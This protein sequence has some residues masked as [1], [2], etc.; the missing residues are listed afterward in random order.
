M[1]TPPVGHLA[2][3]SHSTPLHFGCS[4][5][6]RLHFLF[7]AP[8]IRLLWRRWQVTR[9]WLREGVVCFSRYFRRPASSCW[10]RGFSQMNIRRCPHVKSRKAS[11]MS[12]GIGATHKC[13]ELL[14]RPG[15]EHLLVVSSR[16]TLTM[17]ALKPALLLN[18]FSDVVRY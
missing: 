16:F 14:K 17:P 5:S 15:R 3:Q 4:F 2:R 18:C 6:P 7:P 1:S 13:S 12:L 8:I 10:G 11:C 9:C